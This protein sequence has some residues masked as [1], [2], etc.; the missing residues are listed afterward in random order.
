MAGKVYVTGIGAVSA[1]GEDVPSAHRSLQEGRSGV[2]RIDY[3]STEHQGMI[4]A[5]EVRA[6]D[7]ELLQKAGGGV[8]SEYSRTTLLGLLAAREALEHAGVDEEERT[9]MGLISGTTTGGMGKM[10]QYYHDYLETGE[11]SAYIHLHDCGDSTEKIARELGIRGYQT[12][13]NTACSSSANAIILGARM[14]RMGAIDRVVAGG[15]DALTRFT[16]NGFNSLYILD[17]EPCKPFDNDRQGLNLGEGGGYVV[18]ES[19][20]AVNE[21]GNTPLAEVLGYSNTNDAYHQTASSPEGYGAFLAMEQA[22]AGAGVAPEAV[23]YVNVHGTGTPNNDLSE[24]MAMRKLFGDQVPLFSSTKAFTGHTLGAAGGLEAVFS[25]LSI[26]DQEIYPNLH[27]A[28][29]IGDLN[30]TPVR[31]YR[32]GLNISYVL[33]NSFGF[34]GNNS[35]LL[36]GWS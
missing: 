36:F 13:I 16:L 18:L 4:P 35:S 22:L 12:T 27:F 34:G 14:I 26:R 3:L 11:H 5:A 20:K 9:S 30:I 10:E 32:K 19:E 25:V 7:E 6:T 1:I 33:S 2:G 28:T 23:S 17:R 15:T 24:G 21:K 8:P 29:P 31:S